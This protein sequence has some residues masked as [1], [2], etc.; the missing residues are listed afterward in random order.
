MCDGCKSMERHRIVHNLFSM[1]APLLKEC[2]ALQFAPDSSVNKQWF[3]EYVGSVYGSENSL[4][5]M[6]TGLDDGRFDLVISNH[7]LEHVPGDI[8]AIREMVRVAGQDGV[9][10]LTVPTPTMRWETLDWGWADPSINYHYRDYG[11]DF[12]HRIGKEIPG[13]QIVS[14]CGQDPVTGIHDIVY[15]ISASESRLNKWA[16]IWA[17]VPVPLV[18]HIS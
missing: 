10:S 15:L 13:L 7:V 14:I 6:E 11:A 2:K 8:A 16:G 5:M 1:V 4:N 17:K 9:V 3:S 12:P 18:R